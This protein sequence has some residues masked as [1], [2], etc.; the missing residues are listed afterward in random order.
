MDQVC[1][2]DLMKDLKRQCVGAMTL[3]AQDGTFPPQ[4]QYWGQRGLIMK[5]NDIFLALAEWRRC[6]AAQ[7]KSVL[8]LLLD[9]LLLFDPNGSTNEITHVTRGLMHKILLAC[10]KHADV[11]LAEEVIDVFTM[12]RV[13]PTRKSHCAM[14]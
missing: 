2:M 12:L 1:L 11:E 4:L 9:I 6:G 5:R 7:K 8:P 14:V 3:L 13:R 10:A